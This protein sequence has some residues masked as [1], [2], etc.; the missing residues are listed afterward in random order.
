MCSRQQVCKHSW[1]KI[2]KNNWFSYGSD[3]TVTT[4]D[5]WRHSRDSCWISYFCARS[6]NMEL[7]NIAVAVKSRYFPNWHKNWCYK[8]GLA[9]SEMWSESADSTLAPH[10]SHL[11][12]AISALRISAPVKVEAPQVAYSSRLMSAHSCSEETYNCSLSKTEAHC[13]TPKYRF[14]LLAFSFF[15]LMRIRCWVS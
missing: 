15:F 11:Q 12:T 1:T 5:M 9:F 10:G 2:D 7:V 13:Q 14:R 3:F 8:F 6:C 4:A